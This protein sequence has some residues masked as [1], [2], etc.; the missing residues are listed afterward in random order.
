MYVPL[1]LDEGAEE[2]ALGELPQETPSDAAEI[3]KPIATRQANLFMDFP[4]R[5]SEIQLHP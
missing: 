1:L 5:A 4:S 2:G 3:V